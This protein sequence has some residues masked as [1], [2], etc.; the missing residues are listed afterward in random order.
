M[1][2]AR[3]RAELAVH[4]GNNFSCEIVRVV[5]DRRRVHV[6]VAAERREAVRKHEDRRPHLLLADEPRRSLRH[7][8]A[9]RLP[10]GMREA[11]A[12]EAD[13]IVEHRE[14]A[15]ARAFVILR[16]QPHAHLAHVRIAER[17]VLE[18]L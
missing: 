16:R 14:T 7:V 17:I 10:V 15:L 9:E 5:A 12:G 13:E 3:Q 11:G 2:A 6:L 4:Q 8:V 1:L 18:D